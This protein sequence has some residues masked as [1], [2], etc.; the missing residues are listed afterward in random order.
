LLF[1]FKK[2]FLLEKYPE[3]QKNKDFRMRPKSR[4]GFLR[5]PMLTRDRN[6]ILPPFA[7]G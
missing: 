3:L 6:S 7:G 1:P 2:V 4:I 5:I